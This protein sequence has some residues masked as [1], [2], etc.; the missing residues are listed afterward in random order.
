MSG[1][2]ARVA[3]GFR[4]VALPL[5]SYYAVTLA[6]PLANGG[7]P[8]GAFMAHALIVLVAPPIAI[9]LG[10]AVH[11]IGHALARRNSWNVRRTRIT[12]R[13]P[14]ASNAPYLVRVDPKDG[15]DLLGEGS[16]GGLSAMTP[17]PA[18]L[19]I[20]P[21][22]TFCQIVPHMRSPR[23]PTLSP[24]EALV[25]E[26]LV[27]HGEMYGLQ[28]VSASR[29]RLKRG[30][31]YVTLGRMEDKGYLRSRLE[32]AP[33]NTGGLPRRL[34]AATALGQRVLRAWTRVVRE[35]LPEF[36]R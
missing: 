3:R 21:S 9:V 12:G 28:L 20:D 16:N 1:V 7:A 31:V 8:S 24:K 25:L 19:S 2:W 10:C 35:L 11:T 29:R 32:A 6:L 4:R 23:I 5:A 14:G 27:Q 33:V 30:T 36:A 15:R 13:P 26:L 34:Y 18:A 17:A 22:L